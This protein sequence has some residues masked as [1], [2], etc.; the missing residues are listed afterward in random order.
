MKKW[1]ILVALHLWM[2]PTWG[3]TINKTGNEF[4]FPLK[5][6]KDNRYLEDQDGKA[7]LYHADT[8]WMLYFALTKEEII[9]YIQMR[10]SQN[11]NVIQ[12][13][14]MLPGRE[15]RNGVKPFQEDTDL[16]TL[17]E[18]YFDDVEWVLTYAEKENMLMAIVPMWISCCNDAWGGRGFPMQINGK[19]KVR[20]FGE[21]IGKKYAHH[22]N[23]IWILGGDN[24]PG[25]NREELQE[26]ALAI[27]KNAPEQLQTYHAASTHSSTDVWENAPWL[28]FSMVYTYFRGFNKAWNKNQPDVYEISRSEYEKEKRIPFILGE[29]TYEGEHGALGG[30]L[31]ARKQ[32]WWCVL[33][34]GFGH[35]Y[36]SPLWAF[37]GNWREIMRYP[38][39]ESL[40]HFYSFFTQLK[41]YEMTP[42]FDHQL[43]IEGSGAFAVN[44]WVTT[45]IA[46][47]K[48]F[49][50]SYLPS[51]RKLKID[52]S[53]LEGEI[54]KIIWFNPRNGEYSMVNDNAPRELI[55]L[56][57]PD[58]EDWVLFVTVSMY[59]Q[60]GTT[61]SIVVDPSIGQKVEYGLGKFEVALKA[62]GIRYERV[63]NL[64]KATGKQI[65]VVGLS[66]GKGSLAQIAHK[67][68]RSIPVTPEALAIWKDAY[69]GKPLL[70]LGGYD[71]QGVM[72]ALLEA[73]QRT[74]WGSQQAPFEFINEI[75][76]KPEMVTRTMLTYTMQR[77]NW[78]KKFY[79]KKYWEKYFDMLAQNRYNS[80]GIIFGFE[81][82]GFLAPP[83]PYF[84]D[85]PEFPDVRMVGL[86]KEQQKRNLTAMN[87]LIEMAHQR[88][89][90]ITLGIWDHIFRGG[91]QT[92]FTTATADLDVPAEHVVWGITGDNL[93]P[94]TKAA[95]SR[96]VE[97][98]P[99]VDEIEFR[100]HWESGLK[101]E[102]LDFFWKDV[103][104]LLKTA[105][106][107]IKYTL[108]AK[109]MPES[110]VQAALDE[111]IKFQI[112]TKYWMEKL[113]MPWHPAHVHPGDQM[114]RRQ[115]YADMLRY[116]QDYK[117][118][119][120]IWASGTVKTLQWG[121]PE[122]AR[123]FIESAKLYD[124]D[125]YQVEEPM[126]TKMMN[127]PTND[128]EPFE[129]L[130]PKYRYYD[131]EFERFWHFYQVFGRLGYNLYQSPDI[132]QKEFENRFGAAAPY[133]Q[134]AIHQASWILPRIE[135]QCFH[136]DGFGLSRGWAEKQPQGKLPQYSNIISNDIQIFASFDEE[137]QLII[138]PAAGTTRA[139]R[140][141]LDR[142]PAKQL[143]SNTS[144]WFREVSE[145]VNDLIRK[146]ENAAGRN[147]S[148][149]FR[150]T[151]TDLKM[152]SNLALY[153]SRRIPAAVSY[154]LFAR[155]NDVAAL[156][157]AIEY[158]K[159]AIV[160]WRQIVEAAGDFF[161][162]NMVFSIKGDFSDPMRFSLTGHWS[163]ELL[164]LE[165]GLADVYEATIPI[166]DIN[167]RFDL[168]Y[169]IEVMDNSGN[170]KIYPDMN[171]QSPYVIV[172]LIR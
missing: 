13:M 138:G 48:S 10:K 54:F 30:P 66:T 172:K 67:G 58:S 59:A 82:W 28:D 155:T 169:L 4:R 70:A 132:W 97:Y 125:T 165:A 64:E 158:E 26:L 36:G 127:A 163:E 124:G 142:I 19:D 91:V 100:M 137:A 83:Y 160:A 16:S 80:F 42:D 161:S 3:D 77:A 73:A 72:Y 133:I 65:V 17:D 56:E 111:G 94:Y 78:E 118:A 75:V 170:G 168:M 88:G 122:F 79:D 7:F 51:Y 156:D 171:I 123:R 109:D 106:P 9:D 50:V 6:S 84:F 121:Q 20:D 86:T 37:P 63:D 33:S 141:A 136:Y 92:S 139:V 150:S 157:K 23:L 39:A 55:E 52:L 87:D 104:K 162:K 38:G 89:I 151:V 40:K 8:G 113:A 167:S 24:D 25:V 69:N 11:F 140:Q 152:L 143:P 134:Q 164:Y 120:R 131:Y 147:Q 115:G 2:L 135:A 27:K 41:W 34:G 101:A 49:S 116:P 110:I 74:V 102:E 154:R 90:K 166:Q 128:A 47:N 81:V 103:F 46:R 43:I 12:T 114:N 22:K 5:V 126:A 105:A 71:D 99:K 85:V 148:K 15:N 93:I 107:H 57:S 130:D 95:L 1:I 129:L 112:E 68:Y 76:E 146:A 62:K 117:V 149:E 145:S 98:F 108:R 31:Q 96:F 44:D 153:H 21:Y 14:L 29:S 119:W 61:Y 53:V 60:Q 18:A 35:A 32:A 159:E 144:V 45:S